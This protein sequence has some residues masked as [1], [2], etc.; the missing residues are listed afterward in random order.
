MVAFG[1]CG[2]PLLCRL[3][4]CCGGPMSCRS[5]VGRRNAG[6]RPFLVRGG[7]GTPLT[8][9]SHGLHSFHITCKKVI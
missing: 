1:C 7:L 9:S 5:I 4:L 6:G 8:E 3:L 2:D